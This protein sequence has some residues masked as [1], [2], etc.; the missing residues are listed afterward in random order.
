MGWAP[1]VITRNYFFPEY[2]KPAIRWERIE[3]V[4]DA[5]Q[6]ANVA[7]KVEV[8]GGRS[9]VIKHSVT[10]IGLTEVRWEKG[11]PIYYERIL[12]RKLNKQPTL[13][14]AVI[15][16]ESLRRADENAKQRKEKK[17]TYLRT[18]YNL[19]IHSEYIA[20]LG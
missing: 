16:A 18:S 5:A 10:V 15:F 9:C 20:A 19:A 4:S 8:P 13:M 6:S 12:S 11:N 1:E 7:G 3:L 17:E 14:Q 2:M